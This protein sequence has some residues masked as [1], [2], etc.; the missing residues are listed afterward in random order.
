[1]LFGYFFGWFGWRGRMSR[2]VRSE[3]GC[4][5]KGVVLSGL[6]KTS[7]GGFFWFFFVDAMVSFGVFV[8]GWSFY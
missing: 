8:D 1:M 5:G 4:S 3:F 2:E 6:G 7:S